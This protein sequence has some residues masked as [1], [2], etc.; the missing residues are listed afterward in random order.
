MTTPSDL[1]AVDVL[2]GW[3]SGEG[4]PQ[5]LEALAR[6]PSRCSPVEVL[7]GLRERVSCEDLCWLL[8][9]WLARSRPRLL[10]EWIAGVIEHAGVCY[11]TSDVLPPHWV[12]KVIRSIVQGSATEA[13]LQAMSGALVELTRR[14]DESMSQ[15][16]VI[17][18]T[19]SAARAAFRVLSGQFAGEMVEAAATYCGAA[20]AAMPGVM[21]GQASAAEYGWQ[22]NCLRRALL[23][24]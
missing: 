8:T 14:T 23:K 9:Q 2:Q 1:M 11:G 24:L 3:T 7:D 22:T 21:A 4:R 13:D 12:A 15:T 18:G 10:L 5:L 19:A 6:L 20:A 16:Y 17:L